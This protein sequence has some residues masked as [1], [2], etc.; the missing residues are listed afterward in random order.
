ALPAMLGVRNL[1]RVHLILTD[2]DASEYNAVDQSIFCYV[3]NA[4]WGR[5]GH[6]LIEK[7]FLKHGPKDN[8][9][10]NLS[11]GQAIL[12]KVRRWVRSWID[13]TSC[14][15]KKEYEF[16][17]ALLLQELQTNSVLRRFVGNKAAEKC[18]GWILNHIV[19]LNDQQFTFHCKNKIWCLHKYTTNATEGM[20]YAAKHS[21]MS[22]QPRNDMKTSASNMSAHMDIKSRDR[23]YTQ[24]RMTNSTPLYF[25]TDLR[26]H[27]IEY[28]KALV[29]IANSTINGG[30]Y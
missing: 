25:A 10:K 5:C 1:K 23:E 29:P 4:I 11:N 3:K 6:H 13:G 28:V 15:S 24:M 27:N 16:S 22:A 9:V 7:T 30:S 2:G 20:N 8:E 21:G 12:L 19:T 14:R 18:V 17:K 26:V